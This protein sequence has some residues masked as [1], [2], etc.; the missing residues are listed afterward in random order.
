MKFSSKIT[1][2]GNPHL[3]RRTVYHRLSRCTVRPEREFWPEPDCY[4]LAGT[5]S[6][7]YKSGRIINDFD[8]RGRSHMTSARFWQILHPPP[9]SNC[10]HWPPPPLVCK[11]PLLA[12][13]T[14]GYLV[15][16][17]PLMTSAFA[18]PPPHFKVT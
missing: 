13:A 10:Q 9:V 7:F 16:N 18:R 2:C 15:Y 11:I 8:I 4:N 1:F 6:T 3:P 12:R 14:I 5:G 17:P